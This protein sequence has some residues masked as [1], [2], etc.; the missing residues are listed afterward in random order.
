MLI[1]PAKTKGNKVRKAKEKQKESK[2]ISKETY[3]D[4]EIYKQNNNFY[5]FSMYKKNYECS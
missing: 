1:I 4:R 2:K 3:K 5:H